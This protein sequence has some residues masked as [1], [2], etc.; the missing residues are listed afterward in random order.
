MRIK[1]QTEGATTPQAEKVLRDLGLRQINNAV[2]L[3]A[4]QATIQ[5]LLT[6]QRFL[7]YGYP[8]KTA[9]NELVRKRG[10]LRVEG[11]KTPISNNVLIEQLLGPDVVKDHMGCICVEDIIDNVLNCDD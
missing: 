11:K 8:T 9:V 6:V 3:R 10:F 5:K 4:D 7:A 1:G 2:F